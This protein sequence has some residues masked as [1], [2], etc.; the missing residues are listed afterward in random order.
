MLFL[1]A[2]SRQFFE[3]MKPLLGVETKEGLVNQLKAARM[4]KMEGVWGN[5]RYERFLNVEQLATR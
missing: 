5:D 2:A 1:R 3:R 4:P